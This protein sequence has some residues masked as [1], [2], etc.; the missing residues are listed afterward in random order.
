MRALLRNS[1]DA[2]IGVAAQSVV[3]ARL[4]GIGEVRDLVIDTDHRS[5]HC[6]LHLVGE[7]A[8]IDVEVAG[9][10]LATTNH[11]TTF[12]IADATTSRE[13]LTAIVKQLVVGRA[14]RVPDAAAG[15]LR[16]LA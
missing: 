3:N 15:A 4:R 9:Y 1:K 7:T 8:V 14:F 11:R 13:W 5:A 16:L 2:A 6:R 10:T 12:T